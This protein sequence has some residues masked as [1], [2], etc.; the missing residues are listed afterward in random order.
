MQSHRRLIY[1]SQVLTVFT[2]IQ[3][4]TSHNCESQHK[5]KGRTFPHLVLQNFP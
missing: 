1:C 5:I 4:D 3:L 2:E